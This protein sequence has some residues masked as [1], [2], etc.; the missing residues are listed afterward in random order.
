[1]DLKTKKQPILVKWLYFVG[2]FLLTLAGMFL[3]YLYVWQRVVIIVQK[4]VAGDIFIQATTKSCSTD[5]DCAGSCGIPNLTKSEACLCLTDRCMRVAGA[6]YFSESK[7]CEQDSDCVVS[8]YEGPVSLVY[9]ETAGG[10]AA[11]CTAGCKSDD[12]MTINGTANAVV[13]R[14]HQCQYQRG[15]TCY[16]GK[17]PARAQ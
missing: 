2:F 12:V 16:M 9:F 7:Y 13:C 8:C 6:D 3:V 15:N 11:D 10:A 5:D 14:S 1:M 4:K 17:I